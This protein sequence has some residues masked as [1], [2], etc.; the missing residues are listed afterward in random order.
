MIVLL[1][2]AK[3]LEFKDQQMEEG[4]GTAP[5]FPSKTSALIKQMKHYSIEDLQKMMG[6]SHSLAE[7]NVERYQEFNKSTV[8]TG[9]AIEAFK[10]DVYKAL[11]IDTLD[12]HAQEIANKKIFILSGLYG[13]LRASDR[14]KPYRLE[15]GT[16]LTGQGVSSLYT[17]WQ[18][19]V[20]EYLNNHEDDT[21]INLASEEYSKAI[22]KKNLK[23]KLIS[24]KF[25]EIDPSGKAK[26]IGILAKKARGLMARYMCEQ[27]IDSM[28][29]LKA[30]NDNNYQF[31]PSASN[32]AELVFQ[33][34]R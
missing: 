26:T 34:P 25:Q 32:D 28:E 29:E 30:F 7:L 13:I 31:I 22:D 6:L 10:G 20:T 12:R 1:S 19:P 15:M 3:R 8:P 18:E 27:K 5:L 9:K 2:P 21:I 17:Y 4:Q 24:I 16:Q 23:K 14:I 33:R 11:S